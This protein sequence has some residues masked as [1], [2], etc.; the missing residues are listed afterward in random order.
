M[1]EKSIGESMHEIWE[2]EREK[3]FEK[4]TIIL[5][6]PDGGVVI[7]SS[8]VRTCKS[9][10]DIYGLGRI[11]NHPEGFVIDTDTGHRLLVKLPKHT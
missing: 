6:I 11:A 1:S 2:E 5:P 8:L 9:F 10:V 3:S 7:L 4:S